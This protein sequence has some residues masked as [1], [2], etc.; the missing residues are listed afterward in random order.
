MIFKPMFVTSIL[1]GGVRDDPLYGIRNT[2]RERLI[3]SPSPSNRG[4][5]FQ[6]QCYQS[7]DRFFPLFEVISHALHGHSICIFCFAH[8]L[9]ACE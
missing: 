5:Y 9:L 4:K 7:H 3:S 6:R 8:P 1:K 2:E